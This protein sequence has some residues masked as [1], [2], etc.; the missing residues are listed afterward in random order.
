MIFFSCGLNFVF[1]SSIDRKISW[2]WKGTKFW[3]KFVTLLFSRKI[4]K[5]KAC[6]LILSHFVFTRFSDRWKVPVSSFT[7]SVSVISSKSGFTNFFDQIKR[8]GE[9]CNS[10][11]VVGCSS[12]KSELKHPRGCI[13]IASWFTPSFASGSKFAL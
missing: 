5:S 11:L 7:F 9:K 4:L 1:K 3:I 6:I 8:K 2:K 10:Y 12:G 13:L